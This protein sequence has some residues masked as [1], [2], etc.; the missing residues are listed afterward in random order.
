MD[1][2]SWEELPIRQYSRNLLTAK[3]KGGLYSWFG[4]NL[5][6]NKIEGLDDWYPL[7]RE[8]NKFFYNTVT[9]VQEFYERG[10]DYKNMEIV[11]VTFSKDINQIVHTRRVMMYMDWLGI[12]GGLRSVLST[13]FIGVIFKAFSN[14]NSRIETINSI[15]FNC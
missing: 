13:V 2:S 3:L 14:K 10:D 7:V 4:I 12:I 11:S 15:N 9:F 8:T 5:R 6:K 1:F